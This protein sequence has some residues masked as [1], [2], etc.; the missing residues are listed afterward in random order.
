MLK[1]EQRR[2][3]ADPE[4]SSNETTSQGMQQPPEA[5][6]VTAVSLQVLEETA[7]TWILSQ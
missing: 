2:V 1:K 5:G 7:D 6:K 3:A 4:D